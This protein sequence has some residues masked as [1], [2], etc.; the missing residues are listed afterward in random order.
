M[1]FLFIGT[2]SAARAN[3]STGA[4][5]EPPSAKITSARGPCAALAA[6][7]LFF[8][9]SFFFPFDFLFS[10]GLWPR[11][12]P[13]T[14]GPGCDFCD[15]DCHCSRIGHALLSSPPFLG[16]AVQFECNT[17]SVINQP[18]NMNRI[19]NIIISININYSTL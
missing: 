1:R 14:I 17:A 13:F 18:L 3:V 6:P 9:F 16:S 12:F 19:I 7:P 15:C 8:F 11:L 10:S 2:M 4:V 5:V